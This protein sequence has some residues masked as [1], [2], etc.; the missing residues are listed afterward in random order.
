MSYL[1]IGKPGGEPVLLLHGTGGSAK[2]FLSPS[3]AG[4]LFG[5]GQALDVSRY[6]IVIPD[7][8]GHGGSA[9]PSDGLRNDFP[10]YDYEDMVDAQFRLVK[11]ALG[12]EHLR[13]VMGN[14][15]GGMHTWLWGVKYY[16]EMDILVP[17]ASQPTA[18]AGRNWILR[19]LIGESIRNDPDYL[20]GAYKSQPR[21]AKL[22]SLFYS[23]ATSGGNLALHHSARTRAEADALLDAQIASNFTAD[24]NDL[25]YQWEASA[26]FDASAGLGQINARVLA[27]NAAD[28]ERNP[29][30]LGTTVQC[31]DRVRYG[32]HLLI[33]A[34]VHTAGHATTWNARWYSG[35][36]SELMR[37]APRLTQ[38][39]L[40]SSPT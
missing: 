18:M 22:I 31:M 28:D 7:N 33:P 30:E 23:F 12:I 21:A 11:E 29:P 25:I 3:F 5:P 37:D 13:L 1:T 32:S 24:A 4:E 9:K 26:N 39:T 35:A 16:K 8:L 15:M 19:R 40:D 10:H 17:M 20:A 36:L 27:I 34:S 6:F 38:K 2:Q 14:S